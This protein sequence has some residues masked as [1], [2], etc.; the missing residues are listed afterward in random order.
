ME[1]IHSIKGGRRKIKTSPWKSKQPSVNTVSVITGGKDPEVQVAK[2]VQYLQDG[3][4][5]CAYKQ[6]MRIQ[7]SITPEKV[8]DNM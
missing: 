2:Y 6:C 5:T 1:V 3:Q 4:M 7:F 8:W